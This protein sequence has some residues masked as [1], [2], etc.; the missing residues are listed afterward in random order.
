M[1]LLQ[2]LEVAVST[3]VSIR[4]EKTKKRIGTLKAITH[5]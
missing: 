3:F 2:I 1:N 4:K 5:F